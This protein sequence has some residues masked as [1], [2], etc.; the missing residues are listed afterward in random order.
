MGSRPTLVWD[1]PVYLALVVG[2]EL[3]MTDSCSLGGHGRPRSVD[4][5]ARQ[6]TAGDK[7]L[8]SMCNLV[9]LASKQDARQKAA[10][11]LNSERQTIIY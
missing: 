3:R 2:R 8:M 9:P 6:R 1:L 4:I 10:D 5:R 11:E 7:G